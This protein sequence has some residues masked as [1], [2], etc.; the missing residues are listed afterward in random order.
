MDSLSSTPALIAR[1]REALQALEQQVAAVEATIANEKK[2]PRTKAEHEIAVLCD[3]ISQ[4]VQM[5]LSLQQETRESGEV[6]LDHLIQSIHDKFSDLFEISKGLHAILSVSYKDLEKHASAGKKDFVTSLQKI[7]SETKLDSPLEQS[8]ERDLFGKPISMFLI[9]RKKTRVRVVKAPTPPGPSESL[10][11]PSSSASKIPKPQISF[12]TSAKYTQPQ[13]RKELLEYTK[14]TNP[15][16]LVKRFLAL[17]QKDLDGFAS[18]KETSGKIQELYS[19]AILVLIEGAEQLEGHELL[20]IVHLLFLHPQ[21]EMLFAKEITRPCPLGYFAAVVLRNYSELLKTQEMTPPLDMLYSEAALFFLDQ[22]PSLLKLL[23]Q[24]EVTHGDNLSLLISLTNDL[25]IFLAITESYAKRG[26]P[27]LFVRFTFA[28]TLEFANQFFEIE[29]RDQP[30]IFTLIQIRADDFTKRMPP[31]EPEPKTAIDL[32]GVEK[33][34]TTNEQLFYSGDRGKMIDAPTLALILSQ[35]VKTTVGLFSNYTSSRDPASRALLKKEQ[36][37]I[38]A[39]IHRTLKGLFQ[40]QFFG[41][42]V[43]YPQFITALQQNP[44]STTAV[45]RLRVSTFNPRFTPLIGQIERKQLDFKKR[46]FQR[47]KEVGQLQ[48]HA[49][50]Q[51]NRPTQS[52]ERNWWPQKPP[53]DSPL[54]ASPTNCAC[55]CYAALALVYLLTPGKKFEFDQIMDEA[56][57]LYYRVVPPELG[58]LTTN[59]MLNFEDDVVPLVTN[60][61]FLQDEFIQGISLVEGQE[62]GIYKDLLMRLAGLIHET[63]SK[64]GGFI[65]NGITIYALVI[66]K[67]GEEQYL[68]TIVDSHGLNPTVSSTDQSDYDRAFK[69]SFK[70]IDDAASF[71]SLHHPHSGNESFTQNSVK[72]LPIRATTGGRPSD[73]LQGADAYATALN[74]RRQKNRAK[75]RTV[76]ETAHRLPK[77][78]PKALK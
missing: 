27:N 37:N 76:L 13:A 54:E 62:R 7:L 9:A 2:Y 57:Y 72:L 70:S 35:L 14:A 5:K 56:E 3:Q 11:P 42:Q 22:L 48:L 59:H 10:P 24:R 55:S 68:F 69:I 19:K 30:E 53:K 32:A 15:L 49:Y 36:E 58:G 78:R 23:S 20:T 75:D 29:R 39:I 38:Q 74:T 66:E 8:E 40:M 65:Q 47:L 4:A 73:L 33:R 63:P 43:R 46:E 12:P 31:L 77:E 34:L 21:A 50:S 60:M 51:F 1:S 67:T 18:D 17:D 44:S 28:Y 52:R 26:F 6:Y 64:V 71:L 61:G 16:P 25:Q 41:D 45:L